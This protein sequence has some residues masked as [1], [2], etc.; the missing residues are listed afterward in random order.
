MITFSPWYS[1]QSIIR[2]H[3]F[4]GKLMYF[5]SFS[6]LIYSSFIKLWKCV[7]CKLNLSESEWRE[8]KHLKIVNF[9]RKR[10]RKIIYMWDVQGKVHR[11]THIIKKNHY[12]VKIHLYKKRASYEPKNTVLFF[13]IW[14]KIFS[15]NKDLY[16]FFRN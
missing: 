5:E 8:W 9:T 2:T 16:I 14:T 12:H 1:N 11:N 4:N 7:T 10:N 15:R 13:I 3:R 6:C